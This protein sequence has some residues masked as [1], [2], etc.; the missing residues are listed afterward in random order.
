M[1]DLNDCV[2]VPNLV[3]K[4]LVTSVI[5]LVTFLAIVLMLVEKTMF[6]VMSAESLVISLATV[7]KTTTV[8]VAALVT[9]AVLLVVVA[10]TTVVN[11]VISAVIAPTITKMVVTKAIHLVPSVTTA[12]ILAICL[13]IVINLSSQRAVTSVINPV[14]L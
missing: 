11:Q 2:I 6:N 5:P 9:V 1:Q 12:V 14:I 4:R 3:L 10:V 7:P 8:M 13:E